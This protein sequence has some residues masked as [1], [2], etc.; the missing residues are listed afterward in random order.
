M[1][2]TKN[3]GRQEPI[4]AYVD[5]A[6]SDLTSAT[7]AVAM[8][9]PVG[10]VVTGGAVMVDTAFNSATSDVL[11]VGD[12]L[13]ANR[14]K[15]SYSIAAAGLTALVPTGY[16]T[17]PTSNQIK[18]TWTGVGAVPT[19]G[20]FTLRVDYYVRKRAAFTQG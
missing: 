9:L 1:A 15:S 14:Y 13:S 16:Q 8:D 11:V 12:A 10:A 4:S 3:K 17:L 20:A 5:V 6:Y 7:A 19:A 18:V 2:I